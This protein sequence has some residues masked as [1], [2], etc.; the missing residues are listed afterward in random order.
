MS[1]LKYGEPTTP[2]SFRVPESKEKEIL[3]RMEIILNYYELEYLEKAE[4]KSIMKNAKYA[5]NNKN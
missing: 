3:K 1:R 4:K 2:V 5:R